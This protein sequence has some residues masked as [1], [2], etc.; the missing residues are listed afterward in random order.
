MVLYQTGSQ[1][2][3]FSQTRIIEELGIALEPMNNYH[4][5]DDHLLTPFIRSYAEP[6]GTLN[7]DPPTKFCNGTSFYYRMENLKNLH[8][9]CNEKWNKTINELHEFANP[10]AESS[11]TRRS[12]V[13]AASVFVKTIGSLL[14]AMT[15]LSDLFLPA[16]LYQQGF[17]NLVNA[18]FP[19]GSMHMRTYDSQTLANDQW[20]NF[21]CELEVQNIANY[22]AIQAIQF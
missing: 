18:N 17:S 1:I 14:S 4:F 9:N 5:Y 16:N 11:R 2:F 3:A 20:N 19:T 6:C 10:P 15:F 12:I 8:E 7:E 13:G 21:K 22:Q